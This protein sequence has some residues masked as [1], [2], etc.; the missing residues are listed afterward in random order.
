MAVLA[1]NCVQPAALAWSERLGLCAA[2]KT[3]QKD[4]FAVNYYEGRR[5]QNK[6]IEVGRGKAPAVHAQCTLTYSTKVPGT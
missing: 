4:R 6:A 5:K 1:R 3:G 2:R